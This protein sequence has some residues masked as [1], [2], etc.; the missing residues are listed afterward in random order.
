MPTPH[1]PAPG[2]SRRPSPSG[3]P[4]RSGERHGPPRV[5]SWTG[6]ASRW[7][8]PARR[9]EGDRG[10]A[11]VELAAITVL[12]AAIIVAVY[13]LE[14]SRTFNSGVRQMVCLVEGPGCGDETWV[15]ADRPEEPEQYEWDGDN[16]TATENQG[17]AMRMAADA[18]WS[19]GEWNCLSNLWNTISNWDH[20]VVNTATGTSGIAGFNPARHGSMPSGYM[21]SPSAQISWGLSYIR[22]T[23]GSPCAAFAEWE[24]SNSY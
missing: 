16:P 21:E 1:R 7:L 22:S 11:L 23:H 9:S 10:A 13:Q 18:G 12:A 15:D 8:R 19:D 3:P 14:L 24:G 5:R 2:G 17:L 6:R 4:G 20:T